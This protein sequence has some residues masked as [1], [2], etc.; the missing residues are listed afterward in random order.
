MPPWLRVSDKAEVKVAR[1]AG[2]FSQRWVFQAHA[3][4][5]WLDSVPIG[6]LD[7]EGISSLLYET[8]HR[9]THNIA[10]GLLQSE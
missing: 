2:T 5:F 6:F 10:P 8:V 7:R 3:S 1:V 9:A 4:G